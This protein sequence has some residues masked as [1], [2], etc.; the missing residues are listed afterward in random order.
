MTHPKAA[1]VFKELSG[2]PNVNMSAARSVPYSFLVVDSMK[3]GIEIVDPTD[4]F[5][6]FLGLSFE[7]PSLASKLIEQ[8]KKMEQQAVKEPISP[9]LNEEEKFS[10]GNVVA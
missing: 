1:G 5:S 8:Y 9:M 4:P 7:S 3:V 10:T 6:F 2:N